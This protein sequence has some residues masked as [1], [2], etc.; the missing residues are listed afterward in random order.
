[1]TGRPADIAALL[2]DAGGVLLLPDPDVFRRLLAPFGAAPDDATCDR[3]H[4]IGMSEVDR[5][6]EADWPVVDDAVARALGV[7]DDCLDAAAGAVSE[8]YLN[9]TWVPV[10]GAAETL[11][12][13]QGDGY[14]LA[15]VSNASGTM[16]QQLLQHDICS[17]DGETHARVTVVIDSDVVGVEK[18]DPRIFALALDA[19]GR[20]DPARCVYVGD[21]VHFDVEG[22][23]AAGLWPLHVDPFRL[24]PATGDHEHLASVADLPAYL[25]KEP[26]NG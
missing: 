1:V 25:R 13:L 22:A 18:P 8:V 17:V 16:E 23:R 4:Y 26:V 14:P 11:V 12:E 19:L 3:A 15:V 6:G 24:C 5:I 10:P 20:P 21:T 9:S 7:P 2:F